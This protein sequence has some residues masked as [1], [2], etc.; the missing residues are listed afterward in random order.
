MPGRSL[1]EQGPNGKQDKAKSWR[2]LCPCTLRHGGF[3]GRGHQGARKEEDDLHSPESLDGGRGARDEVDPR[4][5]GDVLLT[6]LSQ[7]PCNSTASLTV[8][9]TRGARKE[10]DNLHSPEA[11]D[12]GSNGH[13]TRWA[14]APRGAS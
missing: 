2:D 5:P 14:L 10:E 8:V 1:N 12:G 6:K 13:E 11:P 9:A 4:S 3:D 7:T